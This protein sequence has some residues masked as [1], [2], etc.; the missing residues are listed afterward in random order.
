[1]AADIYNTVRLCIDCVRT[2]TKS[3]HQHKFELFPPSGSLE[4]VAVDLF[5]P[6]TRARSGKQFVIINTNSYSKLTRAIVTAKITTTQVAN[7]FLNHWV[8]PYGIP[9]T[10]LPDN[11]QRFVSKAFTSM[12]AY[13]GVKKVS[14]PAY[15]PLANGK[16]E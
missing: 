11:G 6:L 15:H 1:M 2:G 14:A 4:F 9:E 10:V 5:G 16:V 12:R 7:I 3:R 8:I 13:L